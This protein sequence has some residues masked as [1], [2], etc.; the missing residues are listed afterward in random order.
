M[1]LDVNIE[2]IEVK[3][4]WYNAVLERVVKS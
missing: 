1:K 4:K 3:W 2:N